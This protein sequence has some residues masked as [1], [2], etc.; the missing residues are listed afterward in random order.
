MQTGALSSLGLELFNTTTYSWFLLVLKKMSL[1]FVSGK[2]VF[3]V[4]LRA[5]LGHSVLVSGYHLGEY[6][7]CD[8]SYY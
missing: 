4:G 5:F 7:L 1:V 8:L 2:L 6:L 3:L